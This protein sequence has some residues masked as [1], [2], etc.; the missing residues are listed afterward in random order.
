MSPAMGARATEVAAVWVAD[1]RIAR[2]S[3]S[4]SAP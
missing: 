1:G 2:L 4:A 3:A